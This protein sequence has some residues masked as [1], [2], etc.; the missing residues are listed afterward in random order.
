MNIYIYICMDIW[1]SLYICMY[2]YYMYTHTIVIWNYTPI[3]HLNTYL[4]YFNPTDD[5][6]CLAAVV[7]VVVSVVVALDAT[8]SALVP[9]VPLALAPQNLDWKDG[10]GGN[11]FWWFL[12]F[13]LFEDWLQWFS[14][15]FNDFQCFILIWNSSFFPS[16]REISDC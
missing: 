10:N 3:L 16:S 7:V 12:C 15:T 4:C 2:I 14:M 11:C 6:P 9:L 13:F 5:S 8:T 1:I